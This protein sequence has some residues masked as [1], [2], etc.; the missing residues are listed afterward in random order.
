MSSQIRRREFLT[1][2]GGAAVAWPL[3]AGA[4]QPVMPVIGFLNGQSSRTWAPMVAAFRRG[5]SEAGYIEGHNII[6]EYRW[7][8]GQ[9]D[10]L[11]T[12]V[13]EFVQR[14]VSVIVATGGNNPAI[15]AKAATR[16]SRSFSRAMTTPGSTGWSQVSIDRGAT[17]PG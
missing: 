3:A 13:A 11:P 16:R 10:R 12:L 8:E 5:L 4:Q 6:I 2:I 15:A 14:P 1:L 7:A 9:P 17:S